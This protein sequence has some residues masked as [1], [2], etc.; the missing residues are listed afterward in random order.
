MVDRASNLLPRPEG[1]SEQPAAHLTD[2]H[3]E[4]VVGDADL[5]YVCCAVSSVRLPSDPRKSK[6]LVCLSLLLR[7]SVR[8]LPQLWFIIV[9]A[10]LHHQCALFISRANSS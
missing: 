1:T 9:L 5:N 6:A 10:F 2:G 7:A 8:L 3:A 4:H